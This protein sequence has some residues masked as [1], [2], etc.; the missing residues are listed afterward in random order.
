MCPGY[1]FGYFKRN[2]EKVLY[3]KARVIMY[4]VAA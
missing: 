4:Y 2:G 1:M 3:V